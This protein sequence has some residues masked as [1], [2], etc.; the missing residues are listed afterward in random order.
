[1]DRTSIKDSGTLSSYSVPPPSQCAKENRNHDAGQNCESPVSE[2]VLLIGGA[3]G[4]REEA[5]GISSIIQQREYCG[6]GKAFLPVDLLLTALHKTRLG[7]VAT[8]G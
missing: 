1:M 5:G 8:G 7:G 4:R 3:R 6:S 2:G